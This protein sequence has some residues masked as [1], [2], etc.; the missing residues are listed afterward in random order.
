ML[1]S[2]ANFNH[3]FHAQQLLINWGAIF[4]LIWFGWKLGIFLNIILTSSSYVWKDTKHKEKD[5]AEFK[6]YNR[7]YN[8][9]N[10]GYDD[11]QLYGLTESCKVR[12]NFSHRDGSIY[13]EPTL[14]TMQVRVDKKPI[15]FNLMTKTRLTST[16]I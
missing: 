7:Q 15:Q 6:T 1:E 3:A 12:I 2:L 5:F 11:S 9:I 16:Q 14:E 4:D 10:G 13:Q 8:G